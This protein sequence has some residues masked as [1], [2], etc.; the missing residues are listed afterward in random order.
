MTSHLKILRWRLLCPSCSYLDSFS[1]HRLALIVQRLTFFVERPLRSVSN[2]H[3]V[4]ATTS[5]DPPPVELYTRPPP[6]CAPAC[7]CGVSVSCLFPSCC[8]TVLVC[9]AGYIFSPPA[10]HP[11]ISFLFS[12]FCSRSWDFAFFLFVSAFNDFF[13]P[14]RD[15]YR[16]FLIDFP[17]W[18]SHV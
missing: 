5:S 6:T 2:I 9:V 18:F 10:L 17:I 13:F 1:P 16:Q 4:H 14:L 15:Y 3:P 7:A 11:L 8:F 12:S